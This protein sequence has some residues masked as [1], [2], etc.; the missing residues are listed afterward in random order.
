MNR[1]NQN[2]A[3]VQKT[4]LSPKQIW[5]LFSQLT[6][7]QIYSGFED[8]LPFT[9]F[10][11]FRSDIFFIIPSSRHHIAFL[12]ALRNGGSKSQNTQQFGRKFF[13]KPKCATFVEGVPKK[14]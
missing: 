12:R 4:I 5:V 2:T 1:I 8:S 10:C 11:S 7:Q 3:K 6:F 13:G 9:V 14:F